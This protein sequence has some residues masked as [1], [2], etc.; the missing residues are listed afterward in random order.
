[1]IVVDSS[2]WID[3]IKNRETA[4]TA[5]LAACH[6]DDI[7]VGDIVLLEVLRGAADERHARRL[8]ARLRQYTIVPML[9][10]NLAVRAAQNYRI[11]RSSGITIRTIADL[12]IGTFCVEHG[13]L[14]LQH[15]RDF[16][17]M[18]E[19]LGLRLA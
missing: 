3:W 14:L 15:D 16:L 6:P 18:A 11:L 9:D 19:H 2:V 12:L 13:H 10:A 8:E 4:G 17:P 7:V 1:M 5:K